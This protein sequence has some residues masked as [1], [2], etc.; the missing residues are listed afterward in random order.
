M[1]A[2]A[3]INSFAVLHAWYAAL[4]A[5]RTDAQDALTSLSL[6]LQRSGAWLGEQQQFWQRQVRACEEAV[7][8]ARTE[9][10]NR[11]YRDGFG[12]RPD[13][14]V[15]EKNL[16]CVQ[17]RLQAVEDRLEA[18]RRWMLRLPREICANY[19][20]P[21]NR[22]ALFLD[23]DLPAGLAVLARQLNALEQ[24]ANLKADTVAAPTAAPAK[25]PS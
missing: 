5:F 25:E 10:R 12:Q 24:Y 1:S 15:E 19:D 13:T 14:T 18:V 17:A 2:G 4:T 8:Q 16:R 21:A 3:G 20:G 22:L 9:L 7:T 6:A 23:A 11:Q